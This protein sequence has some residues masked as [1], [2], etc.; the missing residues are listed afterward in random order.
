MS[1]PFACNKKD[2]FGSKAKKEAAPAEPVTI[3]ADKCQ[4]ITAVIPFNTKN[5][6]AIRQWMHAHVLHN[7]QKIFLSIRWLAV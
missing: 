2:L 4:V 5:A 3:I 7:G 6:A 1:S